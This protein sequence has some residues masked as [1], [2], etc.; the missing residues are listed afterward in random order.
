MSVVGKKLF[1]TFDVNNDGSVSMDEL[2]EGFKLFDKNGGS[3]SP[4]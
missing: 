2:I 4:R 3:F 1:D